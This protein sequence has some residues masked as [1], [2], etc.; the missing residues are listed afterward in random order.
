MEY[1]INTVT[2]NNL[3][4]KVTSANPAATWLFF[5]AAVL[6]GTGLQAQTFPVPGLSLPNGKT[7]VITYEV[8]V[9]AEA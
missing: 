4:L 5:L 6:T 8:D 9:N 3:Y 2:M 7:V 1:S